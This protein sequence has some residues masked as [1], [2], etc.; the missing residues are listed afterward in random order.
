[1]RRGRGWVCAR[2]ED[3][4]GGSTIVAGLGGGG[5]VGLGKGGG[6]AEGARATMVPSIEIVDGDAGAKICR[7]EHTL[8]LFT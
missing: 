6:C 5:G 8:H 1:L 4:R 3:G 2:G 7:N